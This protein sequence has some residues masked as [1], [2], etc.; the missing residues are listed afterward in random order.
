MIQVAM[1]GH[2]ADKAKHKNGKPL[3]LPAAS[4]ATGT[5]VYNKE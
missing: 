2:V 4:K 5:S 3:P 1:Y